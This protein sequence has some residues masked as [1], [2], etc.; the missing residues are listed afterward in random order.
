M[1]LAAQLAHNFKDALNNISVVCLFS[2]PG[3]LQ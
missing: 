2:N 3:V 1:V